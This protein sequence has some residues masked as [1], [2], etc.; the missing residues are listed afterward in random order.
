MTPERLTAVI[1]NWKT[2]A[3][4]IRSAQALI[5][6]GVP[7]ERIVLVDNGSADGSVERLRDE[8]PRSVLVPLEANV[9]YARAANQGAGVLAGDAYLI[10]NNDAFVSSPGSIRKM[11]DALE[12]PRVGVVVPR[13]RNPDGTLQPT[14]KPLDTPAVALLRASGLSRFVPNR[15]KPRWSTH[16]DHASSDEIRAADGAVVLVRGTVWDELGGF[17]TRSYMYAEDTELCW[18]ANEL[19]WKVWFEAGAEFVHLG[20]AATH[21]SNVERAERWSR[22]EGELLRERL[23]PPAAFL[24]ILFTAAGLA[25]RAGIF[26][27]VGRREHA[28]NL[29]A[30]LRG[31]LSALRPASR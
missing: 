19:G 27:L 28:A 1:A 20:N 17:S 11:L 13:L 31:Y 24:S 22:S 10:V 3:Y 15:W 23:S 4:T 18:H 2:A 6:D 29:R 7:P 21:W 26:R 9:G 12:D 30:Q 5:E 14:V 16:W 25:A 8:L